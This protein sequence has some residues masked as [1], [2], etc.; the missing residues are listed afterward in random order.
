MLLP[1][2]YRFHGL[3]EDLVHL[4]RFP[5]ELRLQ[6]SDVPVLLLLEGHQ[7]RLVATTNPEKHEPER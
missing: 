5:L 4:S 6:Y 3:L 7:V 2:A 1:R